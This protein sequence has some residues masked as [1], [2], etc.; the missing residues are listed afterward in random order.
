MSAPAWP[1]QMLAVAL[2]AAAGGVLRWALG[3]ATAT[4]GGAWPWGTLAANALAALGIGF[5]AA[6]FWAHIELSP[7]WRLLLV[8]GFLGGLSTFSSFSLEGAQLLQNA[9]YSGFASHFLLHNLGSL[10]LV[11]VGMAAYRWGAGA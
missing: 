2:G 10:A 6:Y 8:T 3:L 4:W 9:N 11:F 5:L 1:W 7:L